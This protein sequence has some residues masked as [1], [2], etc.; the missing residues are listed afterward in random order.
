MKIDPT[1]EC[2]SARGG[3]N[4]T[5][6][7]T[8]SLTAVPRLTVT[9]QCSYCDYWLTPRKAVGVV[10]ALRAAGWVRVGKWFVCPQCQQR[11]VG[12]AGDGLETKTGM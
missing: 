10:A 1:V 8:V 7:A 6:T 12:T 3:V 4:A 5:P 9:A 2:R 11:G